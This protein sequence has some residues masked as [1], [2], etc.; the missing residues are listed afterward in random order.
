MAPVCDIVERQL[1]LPANCRSCI[2]HH[3]KALA[4]CQ[5]ACET[6]CLKLAETETRFVV[7]VDILSEQDALQYQ[8]FQSYFSMY[9]DRR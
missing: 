9:L 4:R 6:C 5:R 1:L 7:N 2:A 3:D 8:G